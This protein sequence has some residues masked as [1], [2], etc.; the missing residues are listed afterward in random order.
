MTRRKAILQ[1]A[2]VLALLPLHATAQKPAQAD[3]PSKPI[4][5]VVPGASAAAVAQELAAGDVDQVLTAE[6]PALAQ[7]TPDAWTLAMRGVVEQQQPDYVLLPHTYQTRD[8]APMLAARF[9]IR[10]RYDSRTDRSGMDR[11]FRW[12][13]GAGGA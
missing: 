10:E 6:H 1:C 9:E 3:Y 8:F 4:R 2:A 7:Y 5:V 12:R 11:L 13:I